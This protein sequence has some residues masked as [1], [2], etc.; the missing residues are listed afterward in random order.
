MC[1]GVGTVAFGIWMA[2][3]TRMPPQVPVFFSRPWG[4]TQ[5]ASPSTLLIIPGM[6][7]VLGITTSIVLFKAKTESVLLGIIA[8]TSIVGQIILGT[9]LLRIVSM[10]I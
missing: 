8:A 2:F 5:L 9:A 1:A 4:E 10:I 7:V 6:S 3:G